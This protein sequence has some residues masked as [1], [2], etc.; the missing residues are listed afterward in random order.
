MGKGDTNL[1][2]DVHGVGHESIAAGFRGLAR[3]ERR[4]PEAFK[5]V[6]EVL[7]ANGVVDFRW[8]KP[9]ATDELCCYWDDHD[10]NVLWITASA[11]FVVNDVA[12]VARPTRPT[13]WQK[14]A[15]TY[16]G[17]LL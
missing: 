14:E 11:V 15:G 17:W 2:Y 12:R 4:I 8:Y 9:R 5:I 1:G 16:V 3:P 10:T 6:E 13:T 7:V